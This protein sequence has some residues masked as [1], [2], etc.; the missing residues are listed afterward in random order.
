[1]KQKIKESL[2]RAVEQLPHPSLEQLFA[3]PVEKMEQH[4]WITKQETKKTA[5]DRSVLIGRAISCVCCILLSVIGIR[6]YMVYGMVDTI[7]SLDVNP[8]F[9]MKLNS[10]DTVLKLKG[11]N[12]EA[13]ALLE[14]QSFK[15]KNLVD[16]VDFLMEQ[17]KEGGYLTQEKNAVLLSVG[18]KKENRALQ[19]E[20]S[21]TGMILKSL[22]KKEIQPKIMT[23][24]L[25]AD[26]EL[27]KEAEKLQVS[28]AKLSLIRTLL[29]QNPALKTE[30][31]VSMTINELA[32]LLEE[33]QKKW[34]TE[35]G[36]TSFGNSLPSE[37]ETGKKEIQKKQE[38]EGR[39]EKEEREVKSG[40]KKETEEE[41]EERKKEENEQ[42][43]NSREKEEQ[44][45]QEE[46]KEAPEEAVVPEEEE[47][48]EQKDQEQEK[49]DDDDNDED[50]DN[51]E[52]DNDDEEDD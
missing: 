44:E 32:E 14:N 31:M 4:D 28:A 27:K 46:Q 18:N 6:W 47:E 2:Q 19:V 15:G 40:G 9:E 21:V 8:S 30:D 23:Q 45:K 26:K 39:E 16:T 1:M 25:T 5:Y 43:K 7:V 42:E 34:E 3:M 41:Q 22:E 24:S 37:T 33:N 49:E 17:L 35:S 12:S 50:D 36:D 20:K 38:E 52:D 10:R 13:A 48:A 29:S 51:E 11:L